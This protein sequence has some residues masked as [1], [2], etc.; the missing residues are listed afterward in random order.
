MLATYAE[1]QEADLADGWRIESEAA[2]EFRAVV[3]F[4]PD[5]VEARRIGIIDRGRRQL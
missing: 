3:G 1:Q 2:R 4:A 5:E